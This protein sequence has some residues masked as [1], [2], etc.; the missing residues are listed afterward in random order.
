MLLI[1]VVNNNCDLDVT[2]PLHFVWYI[3]SGCISSHQYEFPPHENI[4]PLFIYN[5]KNNSYDNNNNNKN[6]E[7]EDDD[8]DNEKDDDGDDDV[9]YWS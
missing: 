3:E 1:I 6:E 5:N 2:S 7:E 8:D 4:S 9:E